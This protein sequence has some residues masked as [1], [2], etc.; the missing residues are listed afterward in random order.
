MQGR[1]TVSLLQYQKVE[2]LLPRPNQ[3]A[4][5]LIF[6]LLSYSSTN[7]GNS[8]ELRSFEVWFLVSPQIIWRF[9][10]IRS[11]E[12]SW[13]FKLL[14]EVKGNWVFIPRALVPQYPVTCYFYSAGPTSWQPALGKCHGIVTYQ[15]RLKSSWEI[16]W[17]LFP[18]SFAEGYFP[19]WGLQIWIL[20]QKVH[21][22]RKPLSRL[23]WQLLARWYHQYQSSEILRLFR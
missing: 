17:K 11:G 19:F 21:Q 3:C 15:A 20:S 9:L 6:V 2:A 8:M 10:H 7:W 4:L 22:R 1:Q 23:S 5:L 16:P 13:N 12:C 14:I 18:G